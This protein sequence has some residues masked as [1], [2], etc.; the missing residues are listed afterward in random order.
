MNT[1]EMPKAHPELLDALHRQDEQ[2]RQMKLSEGFTEK[3]MKRIKSTHRHSSFLTFDSPLR[4]VAAIFIASAFLCGLAFAAWQAFS[5]AKE[6]PMEE[7]DCQLSTINCQL[8]TPV[9]FSDVRLD[10][11]LTVVS[12]HYGKAVCFRD[13]AARELRLSTM[14][15]CEDSLSVFIATLNEFDGLSLKEERDTVFV[16]SETVEGK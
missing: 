11:I 8:S 3:M 4:K 6:Q 16:T 14:W 10:S 13:T 9:R 2:A 7:A 1:N 12:S 5:P 15:D